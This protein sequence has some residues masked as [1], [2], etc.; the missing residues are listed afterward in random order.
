LALNIARA[1]PNSKASMR[2][3]LKRAGW[4]EKFL[5]EMLTNMR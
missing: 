3:K 5:L 4:D 1:H 2:A